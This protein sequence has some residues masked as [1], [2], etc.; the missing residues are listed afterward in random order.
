[1]LSFYIFGLAFNFLSLVCNQ[2][3]SCL[4]V[5]GIFWSTSRIGDQLFQSWVELR[6]HGAATQHHLYEPAHEWGQGDWLPFK[7][8]LCLFLLACLFVLCFSWTVG[9]LGYLAMHYEKQDQELSHLYQIRSKRWWKWWT[10]TYQSTRQIKLE[11]LEY[12]S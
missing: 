3:E 7:T 11:Q 5:L 12:T 9:W 1:M 6:R 4:F 10:P 8:L 2:M